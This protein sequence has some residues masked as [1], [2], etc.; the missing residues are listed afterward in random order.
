MF[1]LFYELKTVGQFTLFLIGRKYLTNK[2]FDLTLQKQFKVS[3]GSTAVLLNFKEFILLLFL[4]EKCLKNLVL[5][6]DFV[7]D[8]SI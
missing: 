8:D 1:C 7:P 5:I 2:H 4:F 3:Q 6:Q